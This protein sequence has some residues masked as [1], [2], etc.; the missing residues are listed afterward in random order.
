MDAANPVHSTTFR[1]LNRG[2]IEREHAHSNPYALEDATEAVMKMKSYEALDF[3]SHFSDMHSLTELRRTSSE[4][5]WLYFWNWA[6]YVGVGVSVGVVAWCIK[7]TAAALT[8]L[9]VSTAQRLV[10]EGQIGAAFATWLLLS[11]AFG[12]VAAVLTIYVESAAAGSGIP[13]VKAFLNGTKIPRFLTPTAGLVKVVGIVFS[14]SSGLIIGMEG[15]LI[16]IGAVTGNL[17]ATLPRAPKAWI[18][19]RSDR[20]KR[21]FVTAGAAAGVAGAF[22]SPV[23]GICFAMEEA[24]SYWR[25]S[26]TWRAFLCTMLTT[27]TLWCMSAF[28]HGRDT[29]FGE[30][31]Y[32]AFDQQSL[33]RIWEVLLFVPLGLIGGLAGAAFCSLNARLS[34]WRLSHISRWRWRR[35]IEVLVV[36]TVTAS[37]SFWLPFALPECTAATADYQCLH[38]QNRYYCGSGGSTTDESLPPQPER[39]ACDLPYNCTDAA[40]YVRHRCPDGQFNTAATL[41]FASLD[42]VIHAMLHDPAPLAKP[43]LLLY[44][45]VT[46]LLA[47][48]TYGIQVPSGLFVPC[49]VLGGSFGRLW[50]EIL[51]DVLPDAGI[52]PGVYALVGAAAML[53]GVTRI[54]ITLSVILFETTNQL[55]LITPIMLTIL[56]AKSVADC[57]NIS[58]Y[59]IHIALKCFPYVEPDPPRVLQGL[60]AREIVSARSCV[61]ISAFGSAAAVAEILRSHMHSAFPVVDDDG[62]FCGTILRNWLV[63]LLLRRMWRV[64]GSGATDSGD[65]AA[66]S[67]IE[68]GSVD[69]ERLLTPAD[70]DALGTLQSKP[71]DMRGGVDVNAIEVPVGA[72][73]DLRPYLDAGAVTVSERCPVAQCFALF[74]GLGIQH[75]PVL[76]GEHRVVGTITRQELSTDFSQDLF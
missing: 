40:V 5:R 33:F 59:D 37:F 18:R 12:G 2:L 64:G 54:T 55:Y 60:V 73:L 28:A 38:T 65:P 76:S 26:L 17:L 10:G 52:T 21:D 58:L 30:L 72:T 16:H 13:E 75:L 24:A 20:Y 34:V 29:Y 7:S 8:A 67:A 71:L 62:R 1:T 44:F 32:G 68:V 42:E 25:L 3:A 50:G 35:L 36:V 57:F 19:F 61:T 63:A 9:K 47:V 53:G 11:V 14:V 15:P 66:A 70:F 49:I 69:G 46:F 4:R 31:K 27:T 41:S 6:T 48:V 51:R 74:R 45:F 39:L 22:A 43:A 56:L 23:G